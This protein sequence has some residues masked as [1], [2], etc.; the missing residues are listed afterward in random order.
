MTENNSDIAFQKF[1][2]KNASLEFVGISCLLLGILAK[3]DMGFSSLPLL[4]ND[5]FLSLLIVVGGTLVLWTNYQIISKI[6]ER[7]RE[8]NKQ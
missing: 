2:V 8:Q 3:N 6:I 4:K 1:I 5:N 7:V